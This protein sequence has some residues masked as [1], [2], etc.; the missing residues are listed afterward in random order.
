[1]VVERFNDFYLLQLCKHLI[2]DIISQLATIK[3]FIMSYIWA[4]VLG[5]Y[6]NEIMELSELSAFHML[7]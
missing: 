6:K 7:T 4:C 3:L 1:M 2:I 5:R